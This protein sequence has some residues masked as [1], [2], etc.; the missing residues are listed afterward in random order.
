M[1]YAVSSHVHLSRLTASR[2]VWSALL[3]VILG[4][5]AVAV[6]NTPAQATPSTSSTAIVAGYRFSCGI[7]SGKVQCW[8]DNFFGQLGNGTN[9]SSSSPVDVSSAA[10]FTNSGVTDVSARNNTACAIQSKVLYCWG[11]NVFGSLGNGTTTASNVPVKVSSVT[12]G[13]Q[14]NNVDAVAVGNTHTCAIEG[15]VVYCWGRD[16]D[17]QLGDGDGFTL[18]RL[19][20]NKV[21]D[22][23]AGFANSG[24]SLI[25]SGS[26]HTC[27]IK[28]GVMWCWGNGADG[29]LGNNMQSSS[30]TPKKVADNAGVFT[31]A[32]VTAM[33]LG[34]SATC[35]VA[36]GSVFCWGFS[37]FGALG[38]GAATPVLRTVPAKVVD[39]TDGFTNSGVTQIS[40]GSNHSCV[41]ASGTAYCWGRNYFGELGNAATSDA[42]S[43]VKVDDVASGFTN[44][45]L[46]FIGSGSGHTCAQNASSAYCWGENWSGGLG[47]GV[48]GGGADSTT[49]VEV[50][51]L[52]SGGGGSSG[53]SGGSSGGGSSGGGAPAP[54]PTTT[55]AP[56]PQPVA[57][58]NG[59]LPAVEPGNVLV[60]EGGR[61][62]PGDQNRTGA[63][64]VYSGGG[65][66]MR[67]GA[68]CGD[69]PCP[70]RTSA[71][72][73]PYLQMGP[74]SQ[75]NVAMSGFAAG[76]E[77]QAWAFSEPT[78][79]G[80]F[81][82]ASD[83]TFTGSV[84]IPVL[85]A[86]EHTI[87]VNGTTPS[88]QVRSVSVGVIAIDDTTVLPSTGSNTAMV[89][90]ALFALLVGTVMISRRRVGFRA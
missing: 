54:A 73:E 81:T 47:N 64:I 29:Q 74:G 68:T 66:E 24:V 2:M 85:P 77:A 80:S 72:G 48:S 69:A 63:T 71:S 15:G 90:L 16:A 4:S 37:P 27:A 35:A 11:H 26:G 28:S 67:M 59:S 57:G 82:V 1:P 40:S 42:L 33:S 78:F 3:A 43:P 5:L 84:A 44:T 88:G 14:N 46:T 45:G 76:T 18:E 61:E 22:G 6:P 34:E 53:G 25:A 86:G 75:L 13:F 41:L 58:P 50:G 9:T 7:F 30:D 55:V 39:G 87:Q 36:G 89:T 49:A 56:A 52:A 83:G 51:S 65:F 79:L 10:G 8:G 23:S 60:L 17:S 62:V 70:V 38:D 32:S 21:V 19:T 20:A 31:N 12:G